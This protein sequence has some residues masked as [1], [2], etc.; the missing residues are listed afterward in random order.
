VKTITILMPLPVSHWDKLNE[1]ILSNSLKALKKQKYLN[2]SVSYVF[3]VLNKVYDEAYSFL[4]KFLKKDFILIKWEGRG[5]ANRFSELADAR[6]ILLEYAKDSDYAI[7]VDS[8]VILHRDTLWKLVREDKDIC[9]GVVCIPSNNNTVE[10]GF[11]QFTV[12]LEHGIK[13]SKELPKFPT[14]VG[15][16][17]TACMMLSKKIIND[18]RVRFGTIEGKNVDVAEDHT[19]CYIALSYGYRSWV[20]PSIKCKHYR[21]ISDKNIAFMECKD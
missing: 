14:M 7:F 15:F 16:V 20:I 12:G 11:G 8:D 21:R 2:I 13:F 9:G 5:E 18:D 3:L 17:N 4:T 19:Y 1:W 10:Y 6:N